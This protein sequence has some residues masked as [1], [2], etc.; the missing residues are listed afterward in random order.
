M[1]AFFGRYTVIEILSVIW[2][3]VEETRFIRGML[4]L[5]VR[6]QDIHR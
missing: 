2:I 5:Y 1:V 4:Y 3:C 6:S